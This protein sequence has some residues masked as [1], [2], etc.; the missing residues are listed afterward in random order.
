MDLEHIKR[1]VAQGNYRLT[2]HAEVERDA[3]MIT[4]Q[5]IEDVLLS[6]EAKIVEDYPNDPRGPS[7]LILGFTNKGLPIHVV[8]GL[9]DS[10]TLIII[11]VYRPEQRLWIHWQIRREGK[12]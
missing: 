4:A 2:L 10:E 12:P 8:C 3:D 5:Q 7:C 9:G 6:K 1:L 11:T